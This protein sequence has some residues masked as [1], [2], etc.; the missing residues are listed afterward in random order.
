MTWPAGHHP[1]CRRGQTFATPLE[2]VLVKSRLGRTAQEMVEASPDASCNVMGR[3]D[4]CRCHVTYSL[5][6]GAAA[7]IT[8]LI[9]GRGDEGLAHQGNAG[10]GGPS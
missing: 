10:V 2:K 8:S 4:H 1:V 7:G 3:K 9:R 6:T 5:W